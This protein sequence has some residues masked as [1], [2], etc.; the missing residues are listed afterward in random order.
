MNNM[1]L[2]INHDISI[3]SIFNLHN[4]LNQRIGR[5]TVAEILLGTLESL[6][7]HFTF[8]QLNHKIIQEHSIILTFMY[9]IKT[10]SVSNNFNQ[11]AVGTCCQYLICSQPKWQFLY[12]EYLLDLRNQ[13]HGKL[14]LAHIVNGLYNYAEQVPGFKMTKR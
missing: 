1:S 9:L 14:L 12:L 5:Q 6:A 2:R 7:L 10:S 3:M 13:L 4:I 8:P 11:T